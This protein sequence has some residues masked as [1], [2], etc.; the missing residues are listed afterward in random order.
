MSPQD[1]FAVVAL[2]LGQYVLDGE[3]AFRF[4]PAYPSLDIVS[5]EDISSYAQADFYAVNMARS[6]VDLLQGEN[7]GLI[8]LDISRAEADGTLKHSASVLNIDDDTLTPGLYAEG[9]RV[10]NFADIL[11]YDYIPLAPTLKT[12]LEVVKEAFGA[13]VEIEFAVDLNKDE[14]DKASFYLLQVKPL[15]GSI[16]GYSIDPET[17]YTD[18]MI[19]VSRK[20]MG[21]GLVNDITDIIYVEPEKFDNLR[22]AEMAEEID[23]INRKMMSQG[24]RYVLIG[25]GRWG[26]KDRFLGIPVAWP[27]ISNARVIVEVG[28][29]KFRVDASQGSHFFH[30]V[31]SM[32]IGY[33]SINHDSSDGTILWDKLKK[34]KVIGK[35]RF[36]RHVRFEKPLLIRMDGKLG[37]AVIS[38]S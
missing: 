38:V 1:G 10:V 7:A 29:P 28:L 2:G 35:G 37:M 30:N 6:E 26:T 18:D 33:L 12:V 23:A 4:S 16:A 24:R 8:K 15:V 11:K 32:N 27:Q 9:P 21:N 14:D 34:Q 25:P 36:F 22:T 20:S 31:T 3:R 5:I 19:L 17:V 13:P